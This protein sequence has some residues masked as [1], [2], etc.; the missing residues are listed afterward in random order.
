MRDNQSYTLSLAVFAISLLAFTLVN[1]QNNESSQL[2]GL[3]EVD[4]NIGFQFNPYIDQAFLESAISAGFSRILWVGSMRYKRNLKFHPKMII[5]AETYF[6][7]RSSHS[8]NSGFFTIGPL[9]RY[10][11]YS[12]KQIGF[13]GELSPTLNYTYL[14]HNANTNGQFIKDIDKVSF[15]YYFSPGI[16]LKSKNLRWSYDFSWKFSGKKMGSGRKN[17]ASFKINYHF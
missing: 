3:K 12:Y 14:K 13:F 8:Y 17:T 9:F 10:D 7:Y 15:G 4:Q 2:Q 16:C 5:G 1:A 6:Y 11:I